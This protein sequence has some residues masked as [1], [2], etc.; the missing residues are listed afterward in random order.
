MKLLIDILIITG[1]TW[2]LYHIARILICYLILRFCLS[3]EQQK[4]L[5][6]QVKGMIEDRKKD[7]DI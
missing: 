3:G 7:L 1:A 2:L 6:I 4:A 5:G